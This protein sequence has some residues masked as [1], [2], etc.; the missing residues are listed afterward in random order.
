VRAHVRNLRAK[1]ET[2]RVEGGFIRTIH[3]VGYMISS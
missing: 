1:L 2:D 3:G